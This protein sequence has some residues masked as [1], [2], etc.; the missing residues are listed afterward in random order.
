MKAA[1]LF[2]VLLSS[3]AFAQNK[4]LE[5]ELKELDAKDSVPSLKTSDR[6]YAVQPRATPIA[7][8]FEILFAA[9]KTFAGS[10]FVDSSQIGGE[11][12]YHLND[13]WALAA[14]Y[15]H[16][17]NELTDSARNLESATGVLPD[18]DYAKSRME[19]KALY[20]VFYGKFRF[21]QKQALSFDQYLGLGVAN[22]QLFSGT[23]TG[24]VFEAG[25]AFWMGKM[26]A[27]HLGVKDYF[28]KENRTL[29]KGNTNNVQGYVQAGILL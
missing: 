3:A 13:R 16:V 19:A 27:L 9:N 21:T 15:A 10:D 20:N 29:S 2:L 6:I 8:R 24:P 23:S 17:N 28:Y 18:V 22:N 11:V 7:N 14:A 26:F 12:Q 5:N 25:F 1:L 4:S